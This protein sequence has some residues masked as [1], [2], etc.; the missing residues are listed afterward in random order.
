VQNVRTI[1]S[2]QPQLQV[3]NNQQNIANAVVNET[4]EYSRTHPEINP[5]LESLKIKAPSTANAPKSK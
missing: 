4:L 5:L 2:L 1:R 3:I